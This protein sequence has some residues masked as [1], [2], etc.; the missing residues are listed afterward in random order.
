MELL[1][2]E[3]E[4]VLRRVRRFRNVPANREK[5]EGVDA[6]ETYE[7]LLIL[8]KSGYISFCD[9]NPENKYSNLDRIELTNA[10]RMYKCE[11][12]RI[13]FWQLLPAI[14]AG[15]FGIV[16]TVVGLVLERYVL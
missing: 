4:N 13:I 12:R 1:N 14:V 16:G 15:I 9:S 2:K 5:I 11:R 6:P 3:L 8:S 10:G 7:C